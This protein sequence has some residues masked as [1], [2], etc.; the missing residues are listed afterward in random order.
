[1]ANYNAGPGCTARAIES[2]WKEEG[3]LTWSIVSGY[4]TSKECQS[5]P[6]YVSDIF[7]D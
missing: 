2:A 7:K 1:M 4:F 3:E 6:F 5:A